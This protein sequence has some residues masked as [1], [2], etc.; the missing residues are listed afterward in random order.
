V[1]P[2]P[3]TVIVGAGISG[4]TCAYAL[5]KSGQNILVLEC[6]ERPGGCIQTVEEDGFLFELGP[7]SFSGTEPLF[8]ICEELGI[9]EQ[10]IEAP[11]SA[12]RYIVIGGEFV[13]VP[14]SPGS[15]VTSSLL[16]WRTKLSILADIFRSSVPPEA[17][18]SVA[19]FVR[20]RFTPELLDRLVGPF[21][22]GIYAGDPEKLSLQAAFPNIY[23]AQKASGSVIRGSMRI[24]RN[25]PATQRPHR[26]GLYSFRRGNATLTKA[27]ADHL[28]TAIRYNSRIED[29]IQRD[30]D[31]FVI[32]VGGE[33][34]SET[35]HAQKLIL[36]TPAPMNNDLLRI[37]APKAT[38]PSFE[39]EYAR[40]ALV[41]HG[42]HK[43]QVGTGLR[44]FGFLV[45]RSEKI[46]TLG[47]V[48]NS[49][50]FPGR[51]PP[52]H[53]LLTSFIG[54]ACES[55]RERLSKEEYAG[56]VR[57]EVGALLRV[58]GNP[59]IERVTDYAAA[60]PQYNT[61]HTQRLQTIRDAIAKIPGLWL[62]GNY[63]KGPAID[64]CVEH[65]LAVADEVRIS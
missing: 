8:N 57:K 19:G 7:Q 45:P 12:P 31:A 2:A 23:E 11:R 4:L 52:D 10:L 48:W 38:F 6:S 62:V 21:V 58:S 56:T 29:E 44:G 63:W 20:A 40:V 18:E 30:G 47:T 65:A 49:S 24:S 55:N 54:G 27:L 35:I 5:K 53:I 50:L 15:F 28:G 17:D 46:K 41:S 51:T 26:P 16:S 33:C 60:I 64:A 34:G 37:I 39:I 59:V 22:S 25:K 36:A 32:T 43:N 61:G 3:L 42:Y 13:P 14:L 9:A 1:P